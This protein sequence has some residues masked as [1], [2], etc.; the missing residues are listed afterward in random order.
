MR[1]LTMARRSFQLF[2]CSQIKQLFSPIADD[3]V[4]NSLFIEY[5]DAEFV[6]FKSDCKVH[7][8]LSHAPEGDA[9]KCRDSKLMNVFCNEFFPVICDAF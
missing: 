6:R 9:T 8:F 4:R 2:L 1:A 3:Y 5:D 7:L